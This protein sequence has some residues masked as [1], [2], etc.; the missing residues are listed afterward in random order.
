[1][2]NF[3]LGFCSG[4]LIVGL[5]EYMVL[6]KKLK[7]PEKTQLTK[8]EEDYAKNDVKTYEEV[9]DKYRK[10]E[11][12]VEK[13]TDTPPKRERQGSS[14]NKI[15]KVKN[16]DGKLPV[17]AEKLSDFD[18]DGIK[19]ME[20]VALER[21]KNKDKENEIITQADAEYLEKTSAMTRAYLSYDQASN[22]L[23][24]EEY[25]ILNDYDRNTTVGI[26]LLESAVQDVID[27]DDNTTVIYIA[28]YKL[29][30]IYVVDI[31]ETYMTE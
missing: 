16:E 6:K 28:N 4:G 18:V 10:R 23:F 21:E 5:V 25:N 1:M 15:Y 3:I 24:D 7:Q 26:K 31:S 8:K 13:K 12:T 22:I 29:N 19:N 27:A 2:R 11:Q 17:D 30:A 14:Y 20:E 9:L